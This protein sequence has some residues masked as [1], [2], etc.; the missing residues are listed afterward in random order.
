MEGN[1]GNAGTNLEVGHDKAEIKGIRTTDKEGVGLGSSNTKATLSNSNVGESL[2]L[3]EDPMHMMVAES[4]DGPQG[5][6]ARPKWTRLTSLEYGYVELIKEGAKSIL[7]K[8]MKGKE[9][10]NLDRDKQ[11]RMVKRGKISDDSNQDETAGVPVHPCR[12]Q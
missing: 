4:A 5:P 11:D 7:G 8:R 6:K 1:N 12:A 3:V 2:D 10:S 9:E